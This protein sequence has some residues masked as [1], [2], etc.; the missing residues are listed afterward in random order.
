MILSLSLAVSLS[1]A[2]G[3]ESEERGTSRVPLLQPLTSL[4]RGVPANRELRRRLRSKGERDR[5][6]E[7]PS[8]GIRVST[9]DPL[10]AQLMHVL[11]LL[12][13]IRCSQ[14]HAR[15][16]GKRCSDSASRV[17][18]SS[19]FTRLVVVVSPATSETAAAA[20]AAVVGIERRESERV[21]PV[22]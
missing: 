8:L 12:L 3:S 10:S 20:A 17:L 7:L 13:L 22:V 1:L 4:S 14:V 5:E 9:A 11:L 6:N 19:S 21:L 16:R 18:S 15:E 2:R